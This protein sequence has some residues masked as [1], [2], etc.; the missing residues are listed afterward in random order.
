MID[1]F[2]ECFQWL[3]AHEGGYVDHPDDPGGAT[4]LGVTQQTWSDYAGHKATKEEIRAL[5][6]ADV[7]PLYKRRY[8]DVVWG[9]KLPSGIDWMLCDWGVNSGPARPIKKVQKIIG[10]NPDGVMGPITLGKIEASHTEKLIDALYMERQAFYENLKTF[11]IFGKGWTRRNKE[12]KHQARWLA[13][14]ED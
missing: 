14:L 9:D 3:L 12:T 11:H 10:S 5:T 8:W 6:A 13:G 4:N 7:K 1:N 2:N